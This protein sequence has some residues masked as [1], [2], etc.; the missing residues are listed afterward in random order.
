MK[1]TFKKGNQQNYS[2]DFAYYCGIPHGIRFDAEILIEGIYRLTAPGFGKT[3]AYGNGAIL[4][5]SP[6]KQKASLN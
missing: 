1:V 6:M 2:Q 3:G 4:I 5:H